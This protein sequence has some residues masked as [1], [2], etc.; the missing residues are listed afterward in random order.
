MRRK[1]SVKKLSVDHSFRLVL[2]WDLEFDITDEN[3]DFEAPAKEVPLKGDWAVTV[4]RAATLLSV[5]FHHD[6]PGPEGSLGHH[7]EID[8]ELF[9]VDALGSAQ[10]LSNTGW[11]PCAFPERKPER[12]DVYAGCDLEVAPSEWAE[13]AE[14]SPA[15]VPETHRAY[16]F[17]ATF[18]QAFPSAPTR[19]VQL[20]AARR[21]TGINLE[22]LPHDVRLFFPRAHADGAELWAKSDFL[23]RSSPYLKD[24]LASDFAESKPRRSKRARTSGGLQ[25]ETVATTEEKD[26]PDSDDET[27][28]L[29][30]AEQPPNLEQPPEADDVPYRQ[31]TI[32]QTAFATYHAVLIYLQTGFIHFGP[33]S[34][35]FPSLNS[36][37]PKFR[38]RADFLSES[39]ADKL[40]L[41]LPVSPKSIYRLAHL[42]QLDDLQ[43]RALDSVRSS[44]SAANAA[45]EL[46]SPTAIAYDELRKVILEFVKEN[47]KE[48]RGSEGWKLKIAAIKATEASLQEAA[49]LAEVIEAVADA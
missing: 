40:S 48:V 17:V 47:W 28:A 8:L 5:G 14:K 20:Q 9:W 49:V 34:S 2:T 29:L 31:I 22:Q 10:H 36:P 12:D 43:E 33:L 46:F 4:R 7:V 25:S 27:D 37:S 19:H 39:L 41:P 1:A 26:Y 35:S 45:A 16:Q 11:N 21:L 32:T 38:S 13:A 42:L 6:H 30:F 24:L 15:Y 44:L 23:S 3:L 18:Q